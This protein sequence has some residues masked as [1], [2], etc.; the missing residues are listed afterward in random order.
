[1]TARTTT[2]TSTTA[3]RL[4]KQNVSQSGLLESKPLLMALDVFVPLTTILT[5]LAYFTRRNRKLGTLFKKNVLGEFEMKATV[6]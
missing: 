1:M 6:L 5:G 2:S 4:S 3:G